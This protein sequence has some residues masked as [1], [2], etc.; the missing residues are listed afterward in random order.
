MTW[1]SNALIVL[2]LIT[3][4]LCGSLVFAQVSVTGVTTKR[5]GSDFFV[6][7][8]FSGAI[9]EKDVRLDYNPQGIDVFVGGVSSLKRHVKSIK[10]LTVERVA[11][12]NGGSGTLKLQVGVVKKWLGS[13]FEKTTS[14]VTQTNQLLLRIGDPQ[15]STSA[16]SPVSL[17]AESLTNSVAPGD[18]IDSLMRQEAAKT[19]SPA[20]QALKAEVDETAPVFKTPQVEVKEKGVSTASLIG[21]MLLSLLV[22]TAIFGGGLYGLKKWPGAK[23][24]TSRNKMI[25]VLAQHSL[26]PKKS[27]AVIRVAGETVLVG[28]TDNHISILKTLSL[29]DEEK[30]QSALQSTVAKNATAPNAASSV[31]DDFSMRGLKEIVNDRLKNMRRM[32]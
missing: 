29:L 3:S 14:F 12:A 20:K 15:V 31:E 16:A 25:E 8:N 6:E 13:Q 4:L 2:A 32:N 27:V 9:S 1:K 18:Q 24:L 7:L 11:T 22:I 17:T 21:R 28:V 30:F 10:D 19:A 23:K 5:I 26:G